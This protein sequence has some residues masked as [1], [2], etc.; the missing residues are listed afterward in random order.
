MESLKA[1]RKGRSTTEVRPQVRSLIEISIDA[2]RRLYVPSEGLY[3][4]RAYPQP[5]GKL[6]L[7]SASLRYTAIS[8]IGL[9]RA[10]EYGYQTTSHGARV[11]E[12]LIQEHLPSAPYT[13]TALLL[14]ADSIGDRKFSESIWQKVK[15][16]EV[17]IFDLH[18]KHISYSSMDIALLLTGLSYYY[19]HA[20]N[21][22]EVARY[23]RRL[24][25]I[26]Q[27]NFVEQT[28]L[29]RGDGLIRRKNIL[30]A[31]T[32]SDISSF[33]SQ[34]Y[35][36]AAIAV[37][38]RLLENSTHIGT[39]QRCAETLCRLQGGHGQWP[40]L[41]NVVTGD[42]ADNYPVYS[43]HQGGMGPFALL[44]LQNTLKTNR[45]DGAIF[46]SLAWLWGENE[47]GKAIV[48]E[49]HQLIWRAI[50]RCDSDSLGPYGIGPSGQF[51]RYLSAWCCGASLEKFFN[52]Q[53]GLEVLRETRPYEYG[54]YLWAFA[55]RSS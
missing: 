42:V 3:C 13:E 35:P 51:N 45:Y 2:L 33:A 26:L 38:S 1:V 47:L 29:F 34:A 28:G 5:D 50:Q 27:S 7:E 41:Y 23:C 32:D 39:A 17:F 49:E 22:G 36:I 24:V 6:G 46:K 10:R 40:W 9:Y 54:W 16:E 52:K 11:L 44:E 55:G 53:I 20:L 18:K 14:W 30:K 8:L 12:R 4:F 19:P 43:V 21:Q 37:Y 15:S 31:R 25:E 48:D